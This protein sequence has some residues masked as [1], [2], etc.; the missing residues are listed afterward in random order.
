MSVAT[1]DRWTETGRR[2][3]ASRIAQHLL[4]EATAFGRDAGLHPTM[5]QA[6]WAALRTLDVM[7]ADDSWWIEQATLVGFRAKVPSHE[8]RALVRARLQ[9]VADTEPQWAP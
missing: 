9:T 4:D 1:Q 6:A 3:K 5:A 2:V 7:G 8:T